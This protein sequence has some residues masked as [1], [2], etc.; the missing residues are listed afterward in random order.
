MTFPSIDDYSLETQAK[1]GPTKPKNFNLS[2]A[3]TM[4][5][6]VLE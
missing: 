4:Y 2:G 1:P 5:E 6:F 3:D